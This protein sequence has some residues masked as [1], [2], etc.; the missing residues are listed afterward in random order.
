MYICVPLSNIINCGMSAGHWPQHYKRETITPTPKQIP[1]ET[2]ELL[3][4]IANLFNFNKIFEKVVAEMV[5]ADMKDKLDPSQY[6]N[7]KH[8]SIQHYLVRLIH[9]VLT[10][11]DRNTK[12]EVKAVLCMF[13]DWNQ[14]Y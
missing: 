14:A 6:G 9:R 2:R 13:I 4:P 11:V 5:I 3:R 8:I 7:Q 10:S 12:G 1:A